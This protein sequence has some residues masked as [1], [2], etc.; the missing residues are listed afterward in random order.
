VGTWYLLDDMLRF[1][2]HLLDV[3]TDA[4]LSI[5]NRNEQGLVAERLRH[6][7]IDPAS[8]DVR[9]AEH[10][11]VPQIVAGMSA[12]MALIKPAYSK[13]A[14]APTKLAEYLGCGVPC[15]G[16]AG[17]GDM[18]SILEGERVGVALQGFGDDELKRGVARLVE[19]TREPR[20][21]QR[22]RG[23]ALERFSLGVGVAA[24]AAIYDRL[25]G[26]S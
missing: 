21:Q 20:L 10:R 6:H 12:G 5:V 8:V 25:A 3:K 14:S 11:D 1:F 15:L 17:V 24:Y 23:V 26:R 16:N 13:L 2:R 4:R 22:C 9:A 19:L 7:G 18:E